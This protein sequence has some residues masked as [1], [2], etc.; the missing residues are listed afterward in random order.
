MTVSEIVEAPPPLGDP[1]LPGFD[2]IKSLWQGDQPSF[3]S[4]DSARW[5]L[6][7]QRA[8]L[9]EAGALALHRG[10]IFIHRERFVE[11]VTQQAVAAY[12]HRYSD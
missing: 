2:P 12:R 11:V 4:E 6:Q 7:R 9:V 8:A 1:L 3:P 5:A 10:R